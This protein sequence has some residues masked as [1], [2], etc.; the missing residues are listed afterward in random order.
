MLRSLATFFITIIGALT[1]QFA[2]A[3]GQY[4]YGTGNSTNDESKTTTDITTRKGNGAELGFGAWFGKG[5]LIETF[6]KNIGV[7]KKIA[8][9]AGTEKKVQ[10]SDYFAGVGLRLNMNGV[11]IKGGRAVHRYQKTITDTEAGTE[12]SEEKST[13][14]GNYFGIGLYLPFTDQVDIFTD[15]T[16]YYMNDLDYRIDEWCF[17][18]RMFITPAKLEDRMINWPKAGAGGGGGGG[19]KK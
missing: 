16:R 4:V 6:G 14:R 11:T 15:F 8:R 18:V 3:Q 13:D 12:N 9:S 10:F 19:S 1:P 5:F 2:Y 7:T 17:G